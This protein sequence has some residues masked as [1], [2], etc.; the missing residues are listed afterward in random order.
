MKMPDLTQ[1][2]SDLDHK[3]LTSFWVNFYAK[4]RYFGGPENGGWWV[5]EE[6]L[7]NAMAIASVDEKTVTRMIDRTVDKYKALEW[8]K[9]NS[10]IGGCELHI[11]IEPDAGPGWLSDAEQQDPE[12]GKR[13]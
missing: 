6:E 5:E 2:M 9:L 11:R 12:K 3:G 13:A 8:G 7:V 4:T 1:A 10:I